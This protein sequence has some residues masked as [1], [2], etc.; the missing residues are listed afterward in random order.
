MI[1]LNGLFASVDE[2]A[3]KDEETFFQYIGARLHELC[4][5][6]AR[7]VDADSCALFFV[8]EEPIV[9]GLRYMV[10]RGAAGRLRYTFNRRIAKWRERRFT[11]GP[12]DTFE[13]FAYAEKKDEPGLSPDNARE[14]SVTSQIWHLAEGRIANSNRAM[15]E[16]HGGMGRVGSGDSIAYPDKNLHTTFRGM[17]AVPIFAQGGSVLMA[18]LRQ[19]N[20][21][22]HTYPPDAS[23]S[24][25]FLS[26]Y[27]VIGILK[28]EG[29]RPSSH[30]TLAFAEV[31]R[32]LDD[33][34]RHLDG[35]GH[36]VPKPNREHL[37]RWTRQ[38]GC[39]NIKDLS[40]RKNKSRMSELFGPK[41]RP[42]PEF[43]H[44]RAISDTEERER[45][46]A[47]RGFGDIFSRIFHAEFTRQD[48]ELLVLMA[49]QVG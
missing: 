1:S 40:H 12:L 27:R 26:K 3:Q 7:D 13:G 31:K 46:A 24:G 42:F 10:M 28:I 33:L 16:L 35:I 45:V 19:A 18:R 15:D 21:K 36:K 39:S 11:L 6:I 9:N 22:G 41:G 48:M 25:E 32:R 47:C 17:I 43:L 4:E 44:R 20:P 38:I 8:T 2:S 34:F 5:Q 29:K 30:G 23:P 14:W 37:L 49:M